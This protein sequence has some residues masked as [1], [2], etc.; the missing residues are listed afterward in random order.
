MLSFA[1]AEQCKNKRRR[2]HLHCRARLDSVMNPLCASER[3]E[4]DTLYAQP[5]ERQENLRGKFLANLR[6]SCAAKVD[7][8]DRFPPRACFCDYPQ[9]CKTRH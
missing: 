7:S 5:S 6:S 2:E 8:N 4:S 3:S 9:G 1:F